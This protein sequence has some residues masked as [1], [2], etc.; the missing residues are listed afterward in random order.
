VREELLAQAELANLK[1]QLHPHFLFNALN[2]VSAYVRTDPDVAAQV[3]A[4]LGTLLRHAL[5]HA[6]TQEVSL[7]EELGIV[8]AYLD[9]EQVRFG[10][11][12]Q[13][14]WRVDPE[15]LGGAVPHLLLQPLVENAIRHGL[16]GRSAPGTIE[17]HAAREGDTLRLTVRDDG[18]GLSATAAQRPGNS[19]G[20]GIANV[21][22]RLRQLYGPAQQFDLRSAHPRGVEVT[23]AMPFRLHA[24]RGNPSSPLPAF[25]S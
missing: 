25:A 1:A 13:V 6:D 21:R 20:V 14:R 8:A 19:T 16:S 17:I 18:D 24:R 7:A 10:D 12:L 22:Q 3:I 11:R 23:V 15:L 4:R 5:Q 2:A 9:I